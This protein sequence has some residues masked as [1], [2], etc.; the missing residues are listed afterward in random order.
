MTTAI[1][2]HLQPEQLAALE[3]EALRRGTTADRLASELVAHQLPR[4]ETKAERIA[5]MRHALDEAER[6]RRSLRAAGVPS[7][8]AVEAIRRAREELEERT[9]GWPSSQTQTSS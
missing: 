9:A 8:D 2:I 3:A 5:R 7:I 6:F 4:A 1:T